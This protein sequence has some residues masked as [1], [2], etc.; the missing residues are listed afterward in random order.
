MMEATIQEMAN[1]LRSTDTMAGEFADRV[2]E[3]VG[4][5]VSNDEILATMQKMSPKTL[6]MKRVVDKI[7]RQKSK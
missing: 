3:R 4:D 6:S 5:P 1:V 2:R 7:N